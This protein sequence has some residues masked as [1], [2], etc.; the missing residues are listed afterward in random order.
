MYIVQNQ[1]LITRKS[2]NWKTMVFKLRVLN[3]KSHC[4]FLKSL[5]RLDKVDQYH[6]RQE[7]QT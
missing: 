6:G 1:N 5:R 3:T 7:L 2:D 4:C